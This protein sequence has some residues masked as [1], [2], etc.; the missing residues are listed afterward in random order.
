[1][2]LIKYLLI[3]ICLLI[4]VIGGVIYWGLSDINNIVKKTVETVGPQ[5]THTSVQL[6]SADIHLTEGRGELLGLAVGNPEGFSN[7]KLFS[8]DSVVLDVDPSS[9]LNGVIVIDEITLDG[10]KLLA[11]HK[12]LAET[13]LQALLN[14]MQGS[15]TETTSSGSDGAESNIRLAVKKLRVINN[16]VT[17]VSEKLGNYTLT[18]PPIEQNSIGDPAV[19]LTPDALGRAILKPIL[20]NAEKAVKA[21]LKELA[22]AEVTDKAESKLKEKL[23]DSVSEEDQQ[24]L[25]DLKGLFGK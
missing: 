10:A 9:F 6:G 24:K 4:V 14:G 15:S 25:K 1:M 18:L 5:V 16:E 13:N 11:E 22:K 20:R 12:N 19:G 21:K 3:V 7:N 2:K 17:L 8:I 23:N